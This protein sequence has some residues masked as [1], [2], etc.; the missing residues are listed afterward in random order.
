MGRS[1][2]AAAVSSPDLGLEARL[3]SVMLKYATP[4]HAH[5]LNAA[6]RVLRFVLNCAMK[7]RRA[8]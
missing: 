1:S 5:P 8:N 2:A 3:I 4:A 7:F 6:Q